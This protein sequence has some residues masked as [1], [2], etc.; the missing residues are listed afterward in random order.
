MERVILNSDGIYAALDF[1]LGH[2]VAKFTMDTKLTPTL[3]RYIRDE[4]V[5]DC[6]VTLGVLGFPVLL[7]AVKEGDKKALKFNKMIGF[8]EETTEDGLTWLAQDTGI[9]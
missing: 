6:L 7:T 3:L 5:E 8:E 2:P 9:W 4:L 1:S